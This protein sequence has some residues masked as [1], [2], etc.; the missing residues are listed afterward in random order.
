MSAQSSFPKHRLWRSCCTSG[1]P[2]LCGCIERRGREGAATTQYEKWEGK[3]INLEQW[4]ACGGAS[5]RLTYGFKGTF[6]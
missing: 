1:S 5:Q 4:R 3:S 2:L 6:C